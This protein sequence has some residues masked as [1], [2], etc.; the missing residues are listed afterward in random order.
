MAKFY[1]KTLYGTEVFSQNEL[2]AFINEDR[3]DE[4]TDYN[5]EEDGIE[6]L[7]EAL[8]EFCQSELIKVEEN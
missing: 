3:S 2:E 4:W 5:L 6:G 1:V 7:A 8:R